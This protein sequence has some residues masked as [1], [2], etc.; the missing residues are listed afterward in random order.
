MPYYK[1]PTSD[2][3]E[4]VTKLE[5]GGEPILQLSVNGATTHIVTRRMTTQG[6]PV[7]TVS[8]GSS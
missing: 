3:D 6:R 7:P 4:F 1:V 5:D 2:L 8:G